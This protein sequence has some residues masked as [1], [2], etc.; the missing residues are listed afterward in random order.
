MK[1]YIIII[2]TLL[3]FC[4]NVGAQEKIKGRVIDAQSQEPLGGA[5]I[6]VLQPAQTVM[7]N[8]EG[9]FELTLAKGNY[10]LSVQ[11]LGYVIKEQTVA[12]PLTTTLLISLTSKENTLQEVNVVSTGYQTLPKERATGSFTVIDNKTLERTVSSDFLS[13]LKGVS[14]GLLFDNSVGNATGIS[15][16]GRSTIFSN[17]TPL[18]VVDNFPFDGDLNT[19]NPETIDQI[20]ILKDAAAASIWGV[21]AGNGVIVVTTKKGTLNK[22][23]QVRLKTDVTIGAKPDLFYQ[24]QLSSGEFIELER[25]LFQ[26]GEYTAAINSG[27]Q[28]ISPV[29]A[30]LQQ[31][32]AN[33]SYADAGNKQIEELKLID[34]RTQLL[35]YFYRPS[36]RQRY[37]L[38]IN[39]GAAQQTYYFSAGYDS[40]SSTNT[41]QSDDRISLKGNNN[42]FLL[43]E[44]LAVTTDLSFSRSLN[45]N[46]FPQR[47][48]AFVPYER[49]AD[50]DGN[51][52]AVVIRNALS[53]AYTDTAGAGK[54]LDW[55]YRPLEELQQGYSSRKSELTDYRIN[56]GLNYKLL[57]GFNVLAKYQY[58]SA[59]NKIEALDQANSFY[60]RNL[61]NT[62]SAINASTGVVSR[63][64]P[65]G[66]IYRPTIINTASNSARLQ[67]DFNQSYGNQHLISAIAG[68]E[69]RENQVGSNG[70]TVYGYDAETASSA[71][72]DPISNFTNYYSGGVSRIG[73][74]PRLN[75]TLD[76]YVSA[77]ANFS[78]SYQGKY[79]LTGSV[80]EDES[81]LYGV[82]ANQKGVPLWSAGLLWNLIKET[83]LGINWLS[84]L[85]LRATY[86]YNGNVNSSVTAYLTAESASAINQYTKQPFNQIVNPPNDNLRWEK[87]RN[88]N[89]GL[90]FATL[91]AKFSGSVDW[92]Q[93]QGTDLIATSPIAPQTGVSL[94]T[95]NTANTLTQ[96]V[97]VQLNATWI[98][99]KLRWQ[100]TFIGNYAKD[101]VTK[102]WAAVG[103][104]ADIVK[105]STYSLS[106]L[107]GYPINAVFAFKWA[108]LDAQGN[109][110]GE[111]FGE[112]TIDYTKIRN[113]T[114]RSQLQ[115]FGSATPIFFGS[116]RNTL[117]YGSLE[118]SFNLIYK[119][120]YFIR[121]RSLSYPALFSGSYDQ[122]DY[123]RRWQ[124]AGDEL[125]TEVP[126]LAYPA[127]SGRNDF[128]GYAATLVEKG[129]H[130]RLQ[131]IQLNYSV[132]S[133]YFKKHP[134]SIYTYVANLGILWRANQHQID[135]D[136]LAGY[137]TPRSIAFGIKT[138]F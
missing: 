71:I 105:A 88:V 15:V 13:R 9:Y 1:N 21:R 72:V 116:I 5:T 122:P 119:A 32:K 80:R 18:I 22:K 123:G 45:T 28:S 125:H 64:I 46:K 30:I 31:I 38:D 84:Q 24:P 75:G 132:N 133:G 77:F 79:T 93:K 68:L 96:G 14:N 114:D 37:N 6:K 99:Q 104:N 98:D 135:P 100:T 91:K 2:L 102:Y 62:Y 47:R 137:P 29:V 51:P 134:L 107:P 27:Y 124:K 127:N 26:K 65:I 50:N 89:V 60:T 112:K 59:S 70:F 115:F 36:V 53:A 44:K 4:L 97:D 17:T 92:Y 55:K 42:Y 136:A 138:N 61:I 48:A 94:F 117:S 120:G 41:G 129:D 67:L 118:I 86:G 81:N 35:E 3:A 109:P 25:Y 110:Q 40:N 12:I 95:G 7:S 49:L 20:T 16:R 33:P 69:A 108:G 66:G 58:Y 101:K 11:Y 57:A 39:G 106:P 78:Y 131:D 113:T 34:N 128:Y 19:I 121:R 56:V 126:S 73:E 130:I 43:K 111:L 90:N 54:L 10:Q 85:G 83:K 8:T 63:P 87:V 52:L 82:K 23:P 103:N 76:R 74:G